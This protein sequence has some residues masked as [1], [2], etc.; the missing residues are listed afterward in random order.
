MV[1]GPLPESLTTTAPQYTHREA[2][3]SSAIMTT[4]NEAS[5]AMHW[6]DSISSYKCFETIA[7]PSPIPIAKANATQT[8]TTISSH[9]TS[10][11]SLNGRSNPNSHHSCGSGSGSQSGGGGCGGDC[12]DSCNSNNSCCDCLPSDSDQLTE[13]DSIDNC[14]ENNRMPGIDSD[15]IDPHRCDDYERPIVTDFMRKIT[16]SGD[17]Q[18]E[19]KAC[20]FRQF[21]ECHSVNVC[22]PDTSDLNGRDPNDSKPVVISIREP[23]EP[24][25]SNLA[26]APPPLPLPPNLS[27]KLRRTSC[28]S[29]GRMETII[30]SPIE[31]PIEP[32][33]SVKEILQ[34]FET[35]T[36]L[37]V[38]LFV[39]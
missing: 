26:T 22:A 14:Y 35:L 7:T 36:S 30:E 9:S 16:V 4:R 3:T 13:C 25:F 33:I 18:C 10:L 20:T 8:A 34:R 6:P 38:E 2:T 1:M 29:V 32:K 24:H 39:F 31:D 28:G 12:S 11:D 17:K 27:Q 21:S 19:N 5:I 15:W 37:E 23:K